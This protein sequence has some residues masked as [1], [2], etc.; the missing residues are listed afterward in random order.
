MG[1]ITQS[2]N[3]K[4]KTNMT[5]FQW[6]QP[7]IN[8]GSSDQ[9]LPLESLNKQTCK[10]TNRW[11]NKQDVRCSCPRKGGDNNKNLLYFLTNGKGKKHCS[12]LEFHD[13]N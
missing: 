4:K 7:F 12:K 13:K 10:E 5:Y 6:T 1:H 9:S 2:C 11:R 3:R 8:K